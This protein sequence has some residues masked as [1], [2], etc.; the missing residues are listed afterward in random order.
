MP[1][2]T[3]GPRDVTYH[4]I[5][6]AHGWR[7][8]AVAVACAGLVVAVRLALIPVLP[9]GYPFITLFVGVVVGTWYGGLGPG[10]ATLVW[11]TIGV[12]Y[13]LLS[14]AEGLIT[15]DRQAIVAL[16]VNVLNNLLL[17]V[18][19]AADQAS[20][21]RARRSARREAVR[22]AALE[23]EM[24]RRETAEA[25]L[26][27]VLESTTDAY[28]GFDAEGRLEYANVQAAAIFATFGLPAETLAGRPAWEL[29]P[30]PAGDPLEPDLRRVLAE[31]A[32]VT[33]EYIHRPSGRRLELHA[34]ATAA[35][36]AVFFRD[37]TDERR[38]QQQIEEAQRMDAVGKLAGGVAHEVNNQMTVV[39]GASS[40]LLRRP[41][42]PTWAR[43]E[44]GQIREA[45]SR[46]A[47][48]TGQLLAFGRRQV[49]RLE[50]LDLNEVIRDVETVLGRSVGAAVR[51]ETSLAAQP[52]WVQADRGQM[53]QSLLNLA[54]NARD[55][56]PEG[57][58]LR[59]E[60][61]V[62]ELRAG[63]R[64][65]NGA[66]ATPGSYVT[67][68]VSD[69]GVGMNSAT[70]R[71]A[72]EP[73]FTT[74][75]VGQGTG[76]GLSTV[77]GIVR[78][79][80]GYVSAESAPGAG[81]A[82]TIYL[83]NAGAT[84]P[85]PAAASRP[86]AP[87]PAA[88]PG[89]RGLAL[90]V[91]DEWPVREMVARV[92]AD[93]GYEVVQASNGAEALELLEHRRLD[94]ALRLVVTDLAMP[95]MGG[96]ELARQLAGRQTRPAPVLFISG[97]TDDEVVRRNL[98]AHGQEFL[99]KP[100]TPDALAARVRRMVDAGERRADAPGTMG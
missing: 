99:S 19:I 8:Y 21:R 65:D 53:I 18:I 17:I 32:P 33:L 78:Q 12:W 79:S 63:N 30:D 96:R 90:V 15:L 58:S 95:L 71:R 85:A 36:M 31:R 66:E 5:H 68:R 61:G 22:A 74:K 35:G 45:A 93:Q 83:P 44:L 43:E 54:F 55:A 20:G 84:T 47:A 57:G 34:Y 27:S 72:F 3:T 89:Q 42:L 70:L 76:L 62:A 14:P 2:E 88:P 37:V 98:L 13:F 69:T 86:S 51:V 25:A 50:P 81:A 1:D 60:T 23:A 91:E 97:Y 46:S 16:G 94:G 56:M 80:G 100:F 39:L 92:L 48:V 10:L 26:R 9:T 82:F 4:L 6:G 7:G 41:D 24:A 40:F 29:W 75:P 64:A 59:I 38:A 73:F 49:L 67:L 87:H 77:Y 52:A 11:G 28:V